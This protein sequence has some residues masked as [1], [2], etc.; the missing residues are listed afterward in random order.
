MAYNRKD[1]GGAREFYG[2]FLVSSQ[3]A[4]KVYQ[5][6][7]TGEGKFTEFKIF[8]SLMPDGSFAEQ[9]V[10]VDGNALNGISDSF[11][12]KEMVNWMGKKGYQMITDTLDFPSKASPS[13]IFRQKIQEFVKKK[14]EEGNKVWSDW[15]KFKGGLNAPECKML[16]QGV[17][18]A[19]DG[20]KCKNKERKVVAIAP[21]VLI[22]PR[23][24]TSDLERQLITPIE[25]SKP[26]SATN[27]LIGDVT[28]PQHGH[29]VKVEM[30]TNAEGKERYRCVRGEPY[31]LPEDYAR[32]TFVPWDKLLRIETAAWQIARLIE[33]F[34]AASVEYA[35]SED[36]EYG[37]LLPSIAR[38]AYFGKKASV[39]VPDDI[40]YQFPQP[41]HNPVAPAQYAPMP[42]Y[43]QPVYQQPPMQRPAQQAFVQPQAATPPP[44]PPAP[45]YPPIVGADEVDDKTEWDT[46]QPV[47]NEGRH[48]T[49]PTQTAGQ[50][51]SAIM[52]ALQEAKAK[53]MASKTPK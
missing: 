48:Y 18:L 10:P 11:H 24:A 7:S 9:V 46:K 42:G 35:F 49:P 6:R 21:V 39:T 20:E 28:S 19:L 36:P 50:G 53:A 12:C 3:Y 51:N 38:G 15:L 40:P 29:M 13:T 31:P 47:V 34:D 1:S 2:N 45:A 23:S 4:H 37:P 8:A 17:L 52:A 14:G 33:T 5:V 25:S 30:F 16:V 32:K 43:T 41:A 27:S 22:L 26:L 44:P